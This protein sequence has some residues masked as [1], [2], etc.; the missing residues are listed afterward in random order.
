M[1]VVM[2][3]VMPVTAVMLPVGVRA[4][5]SDGQRSPREGHRNH[6]HQGCPESLHRIPPKISL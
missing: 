5:A 1:L 6:D 3:M 4:V 2:M